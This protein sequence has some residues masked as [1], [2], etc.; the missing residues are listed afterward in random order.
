ME[1]TWRFVGKGSD[2]V[3]TDVTVVADGKEH[4]LGEFI[5]KCETI[6]AADLKGANEV[7]GV[8]CL[9][10]DKGTEIGVFRS[11]SKYLV[12]KGDIVIGD[13]QNPGKRGP[14]VT[15]LTLP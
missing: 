8:L 4:L 10:D 3:T 1:F 2:Q 9:V 13:T 14:F 6:A 11:G 5:G 15:I 7:S 12:Q